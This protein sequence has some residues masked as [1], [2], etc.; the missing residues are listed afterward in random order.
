MKMRD[1]IMVGVAGILTTMFVLFILLLNSCAT[2]APSA[3]VQ[4]CDEY[5]ERRV[6]S[7]AKQGTTVVN[8]GSEVTTEGIILWMQ[9]ASRTSEEIY[10]DVL[11]DTEL[12]GAAL[13]KEGL[14]LVDTCDR[15]GHTWQIYTSVV[16]MI[17]GRE[18]QGTH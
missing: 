9:F 17:K 14:K 6:A 11:V 4:T 8:S 13:A 5:V 1:T 18:A 12:A 15:G 10:F 3:A 16:K 7:H 2:T